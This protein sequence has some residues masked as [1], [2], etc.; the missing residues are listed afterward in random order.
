MDELEDHKINTWRGWYLAFSEHL[1]ECHVLSL[2]IFMHGYPVPISGCYLACI[3]KVLHLNIGSSH[4]D[5]PSYVISIHSDEVYLF[6]SELS[7]N[8]WV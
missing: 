6:I 5:E 7:L 3:N 4:M 8:P 1:S 2:V